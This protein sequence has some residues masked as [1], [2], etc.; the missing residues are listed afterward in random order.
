MHCPHLCFVFRLLFEKDSEIEKVAV[1][2]ISHNKLE[3]VLNDK[4]GILIVPLEKDL[5]FTV[6]RYTDAEIFAARHPNDLP[7]PSCIYIRIDA[8]QRGLGTGSCG[9]QTLEKYRLN[10]GL[11]QVS[12]WIC[13]V[14][15]K[16]E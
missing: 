8:A 3:D 15:K 9:P 6:S 12:F 4:T 11:Y 5:Q 7:P 16:E 13:P 10:G 1:P 14:C 2:T